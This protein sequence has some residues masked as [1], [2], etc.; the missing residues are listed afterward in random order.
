M[1]THRKP[2]PKSRRIVGLFVASLLCASGCQ[3]LGKIKDK[4]YNTARS[5]I[6]KSYNDPRAEAKVAEAEELYNNQQYEKAQDIFADV[7]EN[8]YNPVLLA[9]KA[10]YFEAQCLEA[11]GHYVDAVAAYNRMLKDFPAG[12]F[13][14][15][16]T[17]RM[18]KIAYEQWL[19]P[20]VL[21]EIKANASGQTTE[22]WTKV[23]LPNFTDPGLP[24]FDIEGEA[25]NT[26]ENVSV[27]DITGPNAD[28]ALFWCGYV[29]FYHERYDDADFY[30]SQL[31]EMHPDSKLR[32]HALRMA[33]MAKRLSTGGAVYDS[34]KAAEA[35]QLVHHAEASEPQFTQD[36]KEAQWLT[37]Q[38]LR[39][40]F[41]LAEK[42]YQMAQYYERTNHPAAAYFYY[43]L[44]IRRYP[45]SKHAD[46]AKS[47]LVALEQVREQMKYDQEMG[48]HK[49][50]WGSVVK[51][52]DQFVGRPIGK[53]GG[54]AD[55]TLAPPPMAAAP[56]PASIS[57]QFD[58][59]R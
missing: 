14:E 35:L 5:L 8:T 33:I 21:K 34:S 23:P 31:V 46:L 18:Y 40:R 19:E 25:L 28:K 45:G 10:R 29:H 9:E 44:V 47:R 50:I 20:H 7:A 37:E 51:Q 27:H 32:T 59:S 41:Q 49:G 57:P 48:R 30:F 1:F 52:W 26:L 53:V 36:P 24:L 4:T 11:R 38:K 58:P 22:W 3:T 17:A 2:G 43:E 55:G 54:K 42:D 39:V 16:A 56:M 12:A 6:T 13:R 15:R